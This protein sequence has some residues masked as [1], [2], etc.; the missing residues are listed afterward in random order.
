MVNINSFK[1]V[2]INKFGW[3]QWYE[4]PNEFIIHKTE[5]LNY[6]YYLI[7]ESKRLYTELEDIDFKIYSLIELK[8][9]N[10][11][12]E[13]ITPISELLSYIGFN[14]TLDNIL[15][16]I[17]D[18]KLDEKRLE[19]LHSILYYKTN[20]YGKNE[21]SFKI[22]VDNFDDFLNEH[23]EDINSY[24]IIFDNYDNS[25]TELYIET[26]LTIDEIKGKFKSYNIII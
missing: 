4:V 17:L 23:S 15:D 5:D 19:L 7:L 25:N 8:Y 18:S 21:N 13:K 14:L 24:N 16:L 22:I 26:F 9:S 20:Q 3:N 10:F 1:I 11:C 6:N 2:E 12:F